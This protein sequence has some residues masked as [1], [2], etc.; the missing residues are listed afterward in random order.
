M[1]SKMMASRQY[2]ANMFGMSNGDPKK[3]K[4]GG[5]ESAETVTCTRDSSGGGHACGEE[6]GEVRAGGSVKQ[7][8]TS[9]ST[10]GEKNVVLTKKQADKRAN[11]FEKARAKAPAMKNLTKKQKEAQSEMRPSRQDMAAPKASA[12][13]APKKG[14]FG[15][16]KQRKTQRITI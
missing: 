7:G 14:L 3:G 16:I 5:K 2:T 15:R 9:S 4:K 6:R 12:K 1:K 10:G 8:K 11:K 13:P